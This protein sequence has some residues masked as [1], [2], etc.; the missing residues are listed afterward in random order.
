MDAWF[1]V[2]GQENFRLAQMACDSWCTS[3]GRINKSLTDFEELAAESRK[4]G[5]L[6]NKTS[7]KSQIGADN[8]IEENALT[9]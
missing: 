4:S 5:Y 7:I 6:N 2:K 1:A 9:S 3:D 8:S